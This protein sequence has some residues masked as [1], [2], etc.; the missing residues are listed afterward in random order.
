MISMLTALTS[1]INAFLNT[2][3][4]GIMVVA[5]ATVEPKSEIDFVKMIV[6][7][8]VVGL[9][10]G[11]IYA[12]ILKSEL[13]SVYSNDTAT[14]YKKSGTFKVNLS[15]EMFMYSKTERK[16]KPQNNQSADK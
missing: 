6:I 16:E 3:A 2:A 9:L 14:D 4:S 12:L 1:Y 11:I 10:A 5:E 15:R 7:A 8:L 13:T